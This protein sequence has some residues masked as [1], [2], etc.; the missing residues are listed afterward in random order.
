MSIKATLCMTLALVLSVDSLAQDPPFVGAWK[1]DPVHSRLVAET[2]RYQE[3]GSGRM[4]FTRADDTG[5]EFA[6]DGKAYPTAPDRSV[7]WKRIG[8]D[9]W[10]VTKRTGSA[11]T[12]TA[13]L[14]LS[15]DRKAIVEVAIGKLPNGIAYRHEK[16]Y[17]RSGT[18][19]G[20]T[21]T[22]RN[23]S[24]DTHS[25]PDGYVLSVRDADKQMFTW[26]IPTDLQSFTGRFD[27]SDLPLLGS[28]VPVGTTFAVRI[29]SPH[30]LSYVAKANGKIQ[31]HGLVTISDDGNVFT[32]DSW[33]P[34]HESEK[35]TGVFKRYSCPGNDKS[36]SWL[37]SPPK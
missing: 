8:A 2:I 23:L 37:C 24:V 27:G 1:F 10:Q 20:L 14:S 28:G 22:W 25:M 31:Q 18:G 34:G 3:L 35:S 29:V 7:A 12:E 9:R 30:R 6:I 16:R 19:D 26:S 32:E 15:P 17:A 36:S 4:R 21:G 13:T 11:I 33:A 5:Y